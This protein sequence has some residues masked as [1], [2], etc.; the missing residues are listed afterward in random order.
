MNALISSGPVH[1]HAGDLHAIAELDAIIEES[2]GEP[3]LLVARGSLHRMSGQWNKA[4]QDLRLAEET[5]NKYDVA[6]ELGQLCYRRGEYEQ[7][8]RYFDTYI[9]AYPQ[10]AIAF[11]L[12]ARAASEAEQYDIAIE[13]YQTYFGLATDP[14]PGEYLAAA[15]LLAPIKSAGIKDALALLDEGIRELGLNPQLQRY[16]MVLE[17]ERDDIQSA[18]DRWYSLGDQLGGTPE[19]SI[20]LARVL[21]LA[22]RVDEARL[23]I[24]NA[25]DKLRK[26]RLTPARKLARQ[27]I[28][29]LESQ[30]VVLY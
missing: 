11:L 16:A 2:S 12:R 5:G 18:L 23:V 4:E 29:H 9:S 22:G 25:K 26:F 21:I 15:R 13:S 30:L 17:L 7:A 24:R 20:T 28:A 10:Q 1:A 3:S 6:F 19:W 27:T 14:Q 8:L